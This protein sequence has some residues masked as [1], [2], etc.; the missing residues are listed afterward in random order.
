MHAV[1][2]ARVNQRHA[3]DLGVA[4]VD[5]RADGHGLRDARGDS[6]R[7]ADGVAAA[8]AVW[9]RHVDPVSD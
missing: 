7:H 2:D 1:R 9:E 5:R 8:D 6:K 4:V 3:V